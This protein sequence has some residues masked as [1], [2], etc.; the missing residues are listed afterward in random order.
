M[1][2]LLDRSQRQF[3]EIFKNTY[4]QLYERNSLVFREY[5]FD[6]NTYIKNGRDDLTQVTNRF[7]K[8]LFLKMFQV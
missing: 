2:D 6:L 4:G 8:Q 5:F 7:F 3:H 1:E